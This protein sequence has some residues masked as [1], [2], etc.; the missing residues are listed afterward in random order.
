MFMPGGSALMAGQRVR[1]AA[2]A[3]TLETIVRDGPDAFYRG[4]IGA[5]ICEDMRAR[6]GFLSMDDL[7]GYRTNDMAPLRASYR[8]HEIIGPPP[9]CSGP[10]HIGQMLALLEPLPVRDYGLATAE[11]IHLIAEALKI[12]F[13]DRIA[14]TADPDFVA[15]PVARLLSP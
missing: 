3:E 10:L 5:A 6:D 11:G 2:Y 15:V 9:P 14:A 13:A 8:G 1:N 7:R 12:A 4:P